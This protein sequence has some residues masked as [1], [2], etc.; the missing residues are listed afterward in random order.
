MRQ[1]IISAIVLVCAGSTWAE[2]CIGPKDNDPIV[3]GYGISPISQ[4][5]L[6]WCDDFDTYCDTNCGDACCPAVTGTDCTKCQSVWPPR[7]VWPGYPPTPDNLCNPGGLDPDGCPNDASEFYFRRSYH[8]PRPALGITWASSSP[9]VQE[10]K[11]GW[12]GNL[13]WVTTPYIVK[14]QGGTNSNQ[15]HTFDMTGAIQRR[16]PGE[17]AVNG[18]DQDPLVLRFWM[19]TENAEGQ[20]DAPSW[21]PLY[22]ELTL[23][24]ARAPTDYVE[25]WCSGPSKWYPIVCQAQIVGTRHS[26]CPPLSTQVVQS[27]AFGQLASV[28]Q[29]PCNDPGT[30]KPTMDHA[31][32]F[33]G[34]V[35]RELRSNIYP[36][37][38]GDF[39]Y[40]WQQGYFEIAIRTTSYSV[41][42]VNRYY[43]NNKWELLNSTATLPRQY[44]GPFNKVSFGAGPSCKL[45]PTTGQCATSYGVWTNW[46]WAN[47]YIDRMALTGGVVGSAIGACCKSDAT[48]VETTSDNCTTMGGRYQGYGTT[49]ASVVCCPI[50]F[51]DSDVDTDV[52]QTDF[53]A[54]QVCYTGSTTGVPSGCECYDRND[55]DKVDSSDYTAFNNC[56]T[57]ANV[58][59]SQPLTPSCTP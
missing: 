4:A 41:R 8:W 27:I 47:H 6:L 52:D 49:C 18:T 50:P 26:G 14:Y 11:R 30:R 20:F 44:L 16:F 29:T 19:Y 58:P 7:S 38:G 48:C 56:F 25:T 34:L 54:F 3:T 45:N 33:D 37:N 28:D 51:A 35:W 46:G 40:D 2:R 57:G 55:D 1:A 32:T 22:A 13:G 36:G 59:W 5:G 39:I 12:D 9:G 17:T 43:R 24:S 23:D 31:V 53:G 15:Y 21:V 42:L 10:D